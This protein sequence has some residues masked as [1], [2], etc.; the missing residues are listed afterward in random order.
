[1]RNRIRP[2]VISCIALLAL[3]WTGSASSLGEKPPMSLTNRSEP[4]EWEGAADRKPTLFAPIKVLGVKK[5][6]GGL[7]GLRNSPS[8]EG[9]QPDSHLIEGTLLQGGGKVRLSLPGSEVPAGLASGARAVLGL[10]DADH[11]ICVLLP[12][13]EVTDDAL[14]T[15]AASQTCG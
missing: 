7:F 2:V 15:W 6:R 12:P 5:E 9:F 4:L 14:A 1:M 10:V 3:G 11:V 8:M 13:A